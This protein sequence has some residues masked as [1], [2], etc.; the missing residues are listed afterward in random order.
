MQKRKWQR[1]QERGQKS[2]DKEVEQIKVKLTLTTLKPIHEKWIFDFNNHMTTTEGEQVIWSCWSTA[3]IP[4]AL[5]C[6]C[7]EPLDPFANIEKIV[8]QPSV[9]QD[10]SKSL[11]IEEGLIQHLSSEDEK[12]SC[13][14]EWQI[15]NGNVFDVVTLELW[16][17][18]FPD[19]PQKYFQ[20][21]LHWT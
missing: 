10:G 14:S 11:Q 1:L 8:S 20:T 21:I 15:E 6:T 4:N 3:G 17:V 5:K 16:F 9:E 2:G 12:D 19:F 18:F 7:L 13:S